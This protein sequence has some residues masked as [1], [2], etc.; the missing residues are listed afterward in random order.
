MRLTLGRRPHAPEQDRAAT[1]AG[2][3]LVLLLAAASASAGAQQTTPPAAQPAAPG[4]TIVGQ[5]L[6]SSGRSGLGAV[7]LLVEGTRLGGATGPDGRFRISGVP[8]GPQVVVARRIGYE[9]Q[10]RT[11]TV[12]VG[13]EVT[14]T[15]TLATSPISLNEV[16]I[17]GTAGAQERRAIGNAV[18]TVSAA[19]VLEKSS[20]PDLSALLNARAPGVTINPRSGRLGAGPSIQIRGRSSLSLDNQP[21]IYVDGVRVNNATS[22]GPVAVS[23]GLGGQGATVGGRLNDINPEDIES[24]EI[25]K[26]PAA[27]TIYGTEAANGVIQI[28]TKRGLAGARPQVNLI[29][30]QGSLHF[31]DAVGRVQTNY[32]RAP[33]AAGGQIVTWNGLQQEADSGR[34]IYKTGQTRRYSGTLSGGRDQLR[35]YVGSSYESDLG[36]EANNTLRQFGLQ[37]N[38]NSALRENT[39]FASSLKFVGLANRLG[40]EVGA[41]GLLGSQ[42][43]HALLFPTTRGFFAIPPEISR[44]LYDNRSDINRFTGSATLTNRPTSWL[45]HRAIAGL[46]YSGEDARAVERFAPPALARYVSTVAASGR[47]GQTLRRNSV[48]TADYAATAKAS[49]GPALLSSTS[50]GGQF[51]KTEAHTSFLG[52]TGFPGPNVESVSA[53]ATQVAATQQQIINTTI[54]AYGEQTFS[55][56]DRLFL[57]GGLRVDNN[58]AFGEDFK[59][60]TYPKVSASWVLNEEPFWKWAGTVNTFR[61]RGAYGESGRQPATFAAL[62]T[63]TP[64]PGPGGTS[65]VTP[66]S[67]GNAN[68]RPERGKE[69]EGG[70]E[71]GLFDRL[72]L[73]FTYYNKRT[74]DVIVNQPVAPS[75]GFPGN[76]VRN[77]GEVSNHGVEFSGTLQA[78]ARRNFAWDLSGNVATNRDRIEDLGGISPIIA[79]AGPANQVGYPVQG[80]F[81]RRVVS[82]D[83]NPTTGQ[84]TNVLCDGGAGIAPLACAQA[85]FVYIGTPTPRVTGG[86]AN[87]FTL[88]QRLRLYALVDFKRGYRVYNAVKYVRCTGLVGG[89]LCRENYFPEEFTPVQLAEHSGAS[90]A[91]GTQDQFFEDASFTKLRELSATFTFPE[92]WVRSRMSL[93]L[94]GRE[95]H[96]WTKYTGVDPEANQNAAATTALQ[97]EQAVTPPLTRFIATLN[98]TW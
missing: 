38:V 83:R 56:R 7:T 92:R 29:T 44:D 20:A 26:G 86:V 68:L 14:A 36:V 42:Y 62:R 96:T 84:A 35:Y 9:Q 8:A 63:F 97:Q 94:A 55:W 78:V 69:W 88:F 93:T 18:T 87:T 48:I 5:V 27:A 53:V 4:G 43:G 40:A 10:R 34:P 89:S 85:P 58:S 64:V 60:V 25:I 90:I 12:A 11:V 13:T 52:G 16:V 37:A 21:L 54:G 31:R 74:I 49:L 45:T 24:I 50:L 91:L 73:D 77:L 6:E 59:W 41:S 79:A 75:S 80:I 1:G 67:L 17:T 65:G 76:Q 66:G 19:D 61:L 72:T 39:D 82:A 71:A 81:T 15:F 3:A 30:E 95:L 70:F 51:Y 23:G 28:I 98:V 33:A 57:T 32:F 46:D 47:I 22:T 2:L